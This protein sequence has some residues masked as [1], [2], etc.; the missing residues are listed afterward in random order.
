VLYYSLSVLILG[1][2][3]SSN[4]PI[5]ILPEDVHPNYPGGFI[6]MAERAGLPVI[7]HIINGVMILATISVATVDLYVA[8]GVE[9]FFLI[10][11]S[12]PFGDV[13]A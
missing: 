7:P 5:L 1:L 9:L 2:T 3:V 11:E 8:V 10:L 6:V 12:L 4:D 13:S